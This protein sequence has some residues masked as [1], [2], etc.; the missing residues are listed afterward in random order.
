MERIVKAP[1]SPE[2]AHYISNFGKFI[3][4]H[5]QLLCP[6]SFSFFVSQLGLSALAPAV[7]LP[8]I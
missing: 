6:R 3:A 8:P 5:C 2:K 7:K 1:D 4:T